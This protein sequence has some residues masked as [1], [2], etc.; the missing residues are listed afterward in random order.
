MMNSFS[1]VLSLGSFLFFSMFL[2][3]ASAEPT[4]LYQSVERALQHSPELENLKYDRQALQFDLEATKGRYLPRLDLSLGYGLEQYSD[5]LSR[6]PGADPADDDWD[7]L[8]RANLKLTQNLYSGGETSSR[9]SI[10]EALI[11]SAN[12]RLQAIGQ[13]IALDAVS[14]HLDVYRLRKVV[15]LAEMNLEVHQEIQQSLAEREQAGAGSIADVTLASARQARAEAILSQSGEELER[16]VANYAR[17]VGDIPGPL[18][19]A[20]LPASMPLSLS[21]ALQ[22]I[23]QSNPELQALEAGIAEA[24]SRVELNRSSYRPKIDIELKSDYSDQLEGSRTWQRTDEAMLNL[25]WNL[26]NGGQDRATVGSSMER[27]LQSRS[28]RKVRL[29]ELTE[30]ATVAWNQYHSLQRQKSIYLDAVSFSRQTF[31]AYLKQFSVSQRSLLDVLSAED[32]YFQASRQLANVASKEILAAYRLQ[33]LAGATMPPEG[34]AVEPDYL[35]ESVTP[36]IAWSSAAPEV[37][38]APDDVAPS[39]ETIGEFLDRWISAWELQNVTDYLACYSANFMPENEEGYQDWLD[40]REE[41]L[42]TPAFIDITVAGLRVERLSETVSR[43]VFIQDYT[44]DIYSDRTEKSL[45]LELKEQG[46]MI[47]RERGKRLF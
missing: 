13:A 6:K 43:A 30:E 24:D 23:E 32:D 5:D 35:K 18:G 31:D 14:A 39:L 36:M 17:V 7:S 26:F 20:G 25:T 37:P 22:A 28:A 41:R 19:Y 12:F 42:K 40:Q 8:G 16:A 4:T 9:V 11:D 27:K 45:L 47:V 1:N 15:A 38:S 44:S 3:L 46:W 2:S 29:N 10:Q 33:A 21:D 34:G